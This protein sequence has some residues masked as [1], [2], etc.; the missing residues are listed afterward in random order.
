MLLLTQYL[1]KYIYIYI[2]NHY[3][4]TSCHVLDKKSKINI[5]D[6][7]LKTQ[8]R[9]TIIDQLQFKDSDNDD[10]KLRKLKEKEAFWQNQLKTLSYYGGFN[11]RDARK[12]T[13]SRSYLTEKT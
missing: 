6:D 13:S 11:K 2:A 12:E 7:Q 10:F 8:I 1:D 5:F 9:V 3:S 4:S